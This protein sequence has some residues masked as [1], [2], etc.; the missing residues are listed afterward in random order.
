MLPD[1]YETRGTRRPEQKIKKKHKTKNPF[2]SLSARPPELGPA[3]AVMAKVVR[4]VD[5]RTAKW[6]EP[7][8]GN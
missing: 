1:K 4:T 6:S 8:A 7:S 5:L 3:T 2:L